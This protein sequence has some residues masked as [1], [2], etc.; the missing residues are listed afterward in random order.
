MATSKGQCSVGP[1]ASPASALFHTDGSGAEAAP[2]FTPPSVLPTGKENMTPAVEPGHHQ[3]M[4]QQQQQPQT[5]LFTVTV[6][7]KPSDADAW[8]PG[9]SAVVS[10]LRILGRVVSCCC[11]CFFFS[12]GKTIAEKPLHP[13]ETIPRQSKEGMCS[14]FRSEW[15]GRGR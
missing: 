3:A 12:E 2:A 10:L 7:S 8:L 11:C 13:F 4:Q 5:H 9:V 15:E 1:S 6:G 14:S